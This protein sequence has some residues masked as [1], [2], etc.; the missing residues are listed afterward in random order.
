MSSRPIANRSSKR[1][2]FSI[3]TPPL[4]ATHTRFYPIAKN[5]TLSTIA[6]LQPL[7]PPI[8]RYAIANIVPQISE[9][10]IIRAIVSQKTTFLGMSEGILQ[11]NHNF[12]LRKLGQQMLAKE[13]VYNL[14]AFHHSN[15]FHFRLNRRHISII[16]QSQAIYQ[17]M[18]M[19]LGYGVSHRLYLVGSDS[20]PFAT[21]LRYHRKSER[22]VKKAHRCQQA[23]AFQAQIATRESLI[24]SVLSVG[25]AHTTILNLRE[26]NRAVIR[27]IGIIPHVKLVERR[28]NELIYQFAVVVILVGTKAEG[29]SKNQSVSHLVT[30]P[31]SRHLAHSIGSYKPRIIVE[32]QRLEAQQFLTQIV[33]SP[34][35]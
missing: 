14:V 2:V 32:Q 13:V 23:R 11:D 8:E 18:T 25:Q 15:T 33:H 16:T 26:N 10:H 24:R 31:Q 27:V 34:L 19:S 21:I 6:F 28:H 7:H 5:L 12:P 20:H 9:N 22:F 35:I 29:A 30:H 4:I 17:H 3:S 1:I